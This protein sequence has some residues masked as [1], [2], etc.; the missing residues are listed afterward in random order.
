MKKNKG[1]T[2]IALI[3]IIIVALLLASAVIR[4]LI[5]KDGIIYKTKEAIVR[6]DIAKYKE[7]LEEYKA[8]KDIEAQNNYDL[9]LLNATEDYATYNNIQL[10]NDKNIKDIIPSI[11]LKKYKGI[12]IVE[13]KFSFENI[14]NN[15]IKAMLDSQEEKQFNKAGTYYMIVDASQTAKWISI[16]LVEPTIPVGS[17][18]ILDFQT[19]DDSENWSES[20]SKIDETKNSQYLKVNI[21]I[22]ENSDGKSPSIKT[23]NVKFVIP[24]GE[25]ITVTSTENIEKDNEENE[26]MYKLA[27]NASTGKLE[28]V[29]DFGEDY[30]SKESN[31]KNLELP[32]IKN[33]E[34]S[35]IDL[36]NNQNDKVN[37]TILYS[38]DGNNW[39][40]S[41][42]D[43]NRYIKVGININDNSIK[44]GKISEKTT[45]VS[46]K[47]S[48][49]NSTTKSKGYITSNIET[50][51]FDAGELGSWT[52]LQTDEYKPDGTA[53]K[54]EF[55]KKSQDNKLWLEYS[56]DI[57]KY[58]KSSA[59]RVK[60]SYLKENKNCEDAKLN[61]IKA[62]FNTDDGKIKYQSTMEDA[63]SGLIGNIS[64]ANIG[65]GYYK[66]K[67]NGETY[68]IHAYVFDGNQVWDSK[69]FGDEKDVATQNQYA[70]CM[71]VIK[72]NGN[73][74]VNKNAIITA[75]SSN[76]GGPLGMLLYVSGTLT[77]NGNISMT[78]K[79]AKAI[80]QNVYLWKNSD[81]SY[82]FIPAT[83]GKGADSQVSD[84]IV[85]EG[86]EGK[87]GEN[88][89][90]GGGG[91]G[92]AGRSAAGISATGVRYSGAGGTGTSYSGGTGGG[93][94][95]A[96]TSNSGGAGENNG[97]SGGNGAANYSDH[98]GAGGGAGNPGGTGMNYNNVINDSTYSG[99]NGTG[100][101]LMLYSNTLNNNGVIEANGC[102]GGQATS[103]DL[104]AS[105]GSSG[106]GSINIFYKDSYLNN[107]DIFA[108]SEAEFNG[109]AGGDGSISVGSISTGSY[110]SNRK[111][112]I[113]DDGKGL[114]STIETS[115]LENANYK[116]K[117]NGETY[118]I[119]AYNFNGDQVWDSKTFGTVNDV[120]SQT[121][122]AK[123]MI[124][125]KVNGNL[126]IN[127]GA[128]I[129]TYSSNTGGP[130]GMLL[131]VT[132]TI[133]NNGK[134]SMTAKGAKAVGQNVFLW[135]NSNGN[136]EY[137][138]AKGANG[139]SGQTTYGK[140]VAGIKGSN[141][142][143]RTTGGG[144]SGAASRYSKASGARV[145]GAGTS[146]T[147]YSGGSGGGA[148]CVR[149]AGTGGSATQNGGAGGKGVSNHST[150]YG[151][152]GGAGNPGGNGTKFS[153]VYDI[154]I[155][156]TGENGTGGL[157]MIYSNSLINNGTIEANGCKGG[158]GVSNDTQ[159]AGGSSGAGS[160]NVFY[161]ETYKNNGKVEATSPAQT[162]GGAGG[163]GSI[164]IGNISTDDYVSTYKNY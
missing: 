102:K 134:I 112:L 10:E 129:T 154:P 45:S 14:T 23:I 4:I 161:N 61:S 95:C 46:L 81:E 8:N 56:T 137:I 163:E 44:I 65:N 144:G 55:S 130:L 7:E 22:K 54:Y 78:A 101:L 34:Y 72:V 85:I 41:G 11:N 107:G 146:G 49:V 53:I 77:N 152:G 28:E 104:V 118:K 58:G 94:V 79:G 114:I 84:G 64:K 35:D 139:A 153:K 18:I 93:A 126:T 87:D 116:I 74:T 76:Y 108:T 86:N 75:Y 63:N 124:V 21:N 6:S 162:N 132:G 96:R 99:K 62:I 15:E 127:A 39:S 60:V 140:L 123:R 138:P 110:V 136:Y 17:S 47:D 151:A 33:G 145:S 19:S 9:S 103:K 147:S 83:G 131:C 40:A 105:G 20:I 52:G 80:G 1:I 160:I 115:N 26:E 36:E 12:A 125:V 37:L 158:I 51:V 122:D 25:E 156:Y 16:E 157:L 111:S 106:A 66:I 2:L 57:L 121:K 113:V 100:G 82:E 117:I 97:A 67:V 24:N 29:I 59:L 142:S 27:K 150:N 128:T 120:A 13:G 5:G 50:Y 119:H 98:Y 68:P 143:N 91:S 109:G 43:K 135:K 149:E 159:A 42:D 71:V 48:A 155:W 92:A 30:K 88:R 133:T 31:I 90:T 148:V 164:S 73:L 32:T 70:Q 89:E 3:I 69:T 38:N 141:G